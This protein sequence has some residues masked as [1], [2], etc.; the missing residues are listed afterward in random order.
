MSKKAMAIQHN[1]DGRPCGWGIANDVETASREAIRQYN[2][3]CCYSGEE[4]GELSF[5]LVDGP[6][7]GEIDAASAKARRGK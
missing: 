4:K 7:P 6:T 2:N 1:T 3:H 5:S